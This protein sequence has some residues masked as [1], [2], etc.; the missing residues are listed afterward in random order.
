MYILLPNPNINANY[1]IMNDI[2][3][4]ADA[5]DKIKRFD[6]ESEA[7]VLS[8][9]PEAHRNILLQDIQITLLKLIRSEANLQLQELE[10][11]K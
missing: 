5:L 2:E 1:L 7:I 4:L 8:T 9:L 11:S 6:P 3:R 10:E